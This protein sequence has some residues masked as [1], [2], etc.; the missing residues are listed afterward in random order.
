[1]KKLKNIKINL[2]KILSLNLLILFLLFLFPKQS[3]AISIVSYTIDR[4]SV[5]VF[6]KVEI[7]FQVDTQSKYPMFEYTTS[8]PAGVPQGIGVSVNGEFVNKITN[9]TYKHPAF[10]MTKVKRIGDGKDAYYEETLEKLWA[11]RFSPMEEGEYEVFITA[12]DASGSSRVKAG[13]FTATAPTKPG[14]VRVS[15][16][17][18][19]YFEF[20]NGQLFWPIG[21]AWMDRGNYDYGIY[22][23]TGT[24]Y[25]RPWLAGNGTYSGRWARWK[26]SAEKH[27]NEGH[28]FRLSWTEKSPGS[29]LSYEFF[30]PEGHRQWVTGFL[31]NQFAG[32]IKQGQRYKVK[33]R[34]KTT[35]MAGPRVQGRPYGF[36]VKIDTEGSWGDP[37]VFTFDEKFKN[38]PVIISHISQNKD[39]HV[40]EL[41]YTATISTD[42][43]YL[44]LDNVTAGR[45]YVDEFSMIPVN[46]SG[47]PIGGELVRNPKA[48][49]HTYVEQRS[50]AHIDY[51]VEQAEKNGVFLQMVV[52]D[53]NDW[54]QNHLKVDGTWASEGDGYYQPENTKARWL[55]KQWYRYLVARWGYS[56]AIVA[57]ELNNEGPPNDDP[58]GS[59]TSPHWRTAEAFAKYIKSIDAHPHLA[60]TSFWCCWRPDFWG[61]KTSAFP[62]IDY[63]DLHDYFNGPNSNAV[64]EFGAIA[65]ELDYTDFANWRYQT[66]LMIKNSNIGKPAVGAELG[67]AYQS[68]E[69]EVANPGIWYKHI[70]WV[71]LADAIIF[72]FGY[73]HP[74]HI[75]R[76]DRTKI[77]KPFYNFIKD[78]DYNKGGY[79]SLGQVTASNSDVRV[80]GQKNLTK[81]KAVLW[82]QNKNYTWKN[83]LNNPNGNYG[84]G[85]SISFVMNPNTNYPVIFYNTDTGTII[86][87]E[88][89]KSDSSGRLSISLSGL[90]KDVALKIGDFS[91]SAQTQPQPSPITS[92]SSSLIGDANNDGK[93]DGLDYVIW[94]N[95]YDREGVSGHQNGDFDNN[96]KVDGVDYVLWLTNYNSYISQ[97][98]PPTTGLTTTATSIPTPTQ[99]STPT[100][101]STTT[102]TPSP[103]STA[104][105]TPSQGNIL[106]SGEWTQ[107]AHNAQKTSYTDQVVN[108]PW[109]WKWVWNGPN[110][111]GGIASGKF[112]LPRNIEPVTGNGR[113]YVAAGARGIYALSQSSGNVLWNRN[114]G[115]SINSTVAYD[116]DT[117]SV[118]AVSTDGR[119]YKLNAN[120]GSTTG[121]FSAAG[122][123]TLPLPPTIHGEVVY[124][125]MGNFV[126]AINKR[127]INQ[128]WAYNA[129]TNVDTP[130]AYSATRNTVIA[131]TSDLRVHAIDASSGTSRWISTVLSSRFQGGDPGDAN[132]GR[133]EVKNGWPVIA[134]SNGYVFIKLRKCWQE[135]WQPETSDALFGLSLENGQRV[136]SNLRIGSGGY[137]DGGYMPIGPMPVIRKHPNGKEVMYTIFRGR[138]VI[139]PR[140][141]S[142]FG[143]I[144]LD[145]STIPGVS[146]GQIRELL[147]DAS[148]STNGA[149]SFLLTDEQ[150]FVSMSGDY[151]FGAHWET[152]HSLRITNPLS[153]NITTS[154]ADSIVS[155]ADNC[156]VDTHYI[157]T[158][159]TRTGGGRIYSKGFCIY[160]G[161]ESVYDRYWSE[162]SVWTVSNGLILY[163]SVDGAIVALESGNPQ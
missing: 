106:S 67:M 139:D 116:G 144:P 86:K 18:P 157:P 75:E 80:Y 107:H 87:T 6:E 95:N 81:G 103:T 129:G 63:A 53:K 4:S 64:S 82:V 7:Q 60:S 39:W 152:G 61:N 10:Y 52:H 40:I 115:G 146:A 79:T 62:S 150:P 138:Q 43:I 90:S 36:T 147:Y 92:P 105:P 57:W 12:T 163:K 49:I 125:S 5:P 155:S 13:S 145:S 108:M 161:Q 104:T 160:R 54:V 117:N 20:T 37:D 78:L 76:F 119:L 99:T 111:T 46:S 27:G 48:D 141:D 137:G 109:R 34:L 32:R 33:L 38:S 9:K 45:A 133:A 156:P 50:A 44:Y 29:E 28:N 102:P 124:Y 134:D 84:L 66:A 83:A 41:F 101:T 120:D 70:L 93:V 51:Q 68:N 136:L 17:D 15:K 11:L 148:G 31:D 98:L 94:L 123:S 97:T 112:M 88:N 118:F 100:P 8:A 72:D 74:E 26:S 3:Y 42:H 113:V 96:G 110:S 140:W 85:E 16:S 149:N 122:S 22:K 30:Y 56:T 14:F 126:Y 132:C 114:P 127:T 153:S 162:H 1:M 77:T 135:L 151:L 65:S 130:P 128:L 35:D 55:L 71:G 21:P 89:F 19:R 2:Y 131:V 47:Q 154:N 91:S 24:M 25:E 159:I 58:A 158:A 59:K 69:L 121:S 142:H 143:Q 23:D 73:W